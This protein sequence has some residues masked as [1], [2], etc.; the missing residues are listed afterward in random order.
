MASPFG[1][2][3]TVQ[4]TRP[5]AFGWEGL[6]LFSDTRGNNVSAQEDGNANDRR[7]F[8]P[9]GGEELLFDFAFDPQLGINGTNQEAAIVNLFYMSNILHDLFYHYGFDE[10][11]GNFQHN[12]YDN[13]GLA[14]DRLQA[15]AL[16]GAGTDNAHANFGTPPDGQEPRMQMFV[17]P[18]TNQD[19]SLD[20][21]V[22]IHEYGH[23]ISERLTGGPSN[24]GCLFNDEQMG[25][26]WSDWFALVLT[27]KGGETGPDA[28]EIRPTGPRIRSAPYS[29]DMTLNP[30]TYGDLD[31]LLV[32]HGVGYAWGSM[33]WEMYWSL[34]DQHGF[35]SLTSSAHI[36]PEGGR[37][38]T[39]SGNKIA[40]QLVVDG[41]KLQPCNPSFVE[42]RDAILLADQINN[43]GVNQCPI[44][45]AFAKR[46]LGVSAD[47]GSAYSITDGSEAFDVPAECDFLHVTPAKQ[48]ICVGNTASY[49]VVIGEAYRS[50]VRMSINANLANSSAVFSPNPVTSVPGRSELTISNT[51]GAT[52]G[53]YAITIIG[54][55]GIK[56]E[57]QTVEL[58]IF[59]SPPDV[60]TLNLPANGTSNINLN[61]TFEWERSANASRYVIEVD[62]DPNFS[63]IEY[64]ATVSDT[65]RHLAQI[66]LTTQRTYYWRIRA[67]NACGQ[68]RFSAPVSFTTGNMVC[69]TPGQALSDYSLV[70]DE[71]VIGDNG[72]ISDLNVQVMAHHS[73]VRD[74]IF[75]LSH[76]DSGTTVTLI[77]R[78]NCQGD[79][80]NAT[81]D[82]E[83]LTPVDSLC[84]PADAQTEGMAAI[85]GAFMPSEPLSSFDFEPL[86][87]TW[88]M[89][90]VDNASADSGTLDQWCLLPATTQTVATL[91][92]Q[93]TDADSNLGIEGAVVTAHNGRTQHVA[94]TNKT[95]AYTMTLGVDR[96]DLTVAAT[97]YLSSTV[98]EVA[99]HSDRLT[100]IKNV[101][102]SVLQGSSLSYS[103]PFIEE[104]MEIGDVVTNSVTLTN[105]GPFPLSYIL[106]TKE[107]TNTCTVVNGDFE[108]GDLTSWA[109][110]DEKA[111]RSNNGRYHRVIDRLTTP[112]LEGRISA[113]VDQAGAGTNIL[114]QD[115]ALPAVLP[116][117]VIISWIDQWQN[118]ADIFT[119]EQQFRVELY[120]PDGTP[121]LGELFSTDTSSPL[122]S[123]PTKRE[124]DVSALVAPYAGQSVRLLFVEEDHLFFFNVQIDSVQCQKAVPWVR[125][126]LKGTIPPHSKAPLD[127]V[128]DSTSFYQAGDYFA[129]LSFSGNF[130]NNVA[131]IP[132]TM[133]LSCPT[134]ALLSGAITDADTGE[135]LLADIQVRTQPP[136]ETRRQGATSQAL[137]VAL[138]GETFNLSL[139]PAI[140][141]LTVNA[142]GYFSQ[143]ESIV[144]R[145]GITTSTEFALLPALSILN[146]TQPVISDTV[147][148]GDVVIKPA[149]LFI[150]LLG[151][152][153][154]PIFACYIFPLIFALGYND[155]LSD[156]ANNEPAIAH[157]HSADQPAG[158]NRH[159]LP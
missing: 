100:G 66:G 29:T 110:S 92:G 118:H 22:I 95:G 25:E 150:F 132:L 56:K 90:V 53:D 121:F 3:Q 106:A 7:G 108:S 13:G 67:E 98:T 31:E 146:F 12:N 149:V 87:G 54:R 123:E 143:T 28:R 21:S 128:F 6:K 33:L 86:A 48:D 96:Y 89:T 51:D 74:Q 142:N 130:V 157:H 27:A 57:Q 16:D 81:L 58:S 2:H 62:D 79:N 131:S 37:G 112:P 152:L 68:S 83:T 52:V 141:D 49:A 153:L 35:A 115:I 126:P 151:V 136:S 36:A 129:E 138:S 155:E 26:G 117:Q 94:T 107:V 47:A 103:R 23:G 39:S 44:W 59:N 102:N 84:T 14:G 109:S 32:P 8:R 88:R 19:S 38:A 111:W 24:V 30:V 147:L 64:S 70:A 75:T 65:T 18:L 43:D 97:H 135:P 101:Q 159:W 72:L 127:V 145:Q 104:S 122:L 15:D 55:G 4:G 10:V 42:A 124:V 80:I 148:M 156:R 60:P 61:P 99:I 91:T 78:P 113:L 73:N 154:S 46:G 17:S 82:D 114:Y 125:T 77:N 137:N 85:A 69:S 140:Y 50:P 45:E 139:P 34:V 134:C 133:Q 93:V 120:G 119:D 116:E 11:S 1:W 144:V 105:S 76:L 20:N 71:I 9:D 158:C 63:S 5:N 40:L 41:M